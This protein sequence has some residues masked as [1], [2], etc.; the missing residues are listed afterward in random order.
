[1]PIPSSTLSYSTPQ[2]FIPDTPD[3]D[4]LAPLPTASTKTPSS[5]DALK[6]IP[7]ASS[8]HRTIAD[9]EGGGLQ[10]VGTVDDTLGRLYRTH[11][12]GGERIGEPL[13]DARTNEEITYIDWPEG[14][15]EVSRQSRLS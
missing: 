10:R 5:L 13:R 9:G 2:E 4:D 15:P 11:T 6:R 12:G 14:D 7:T 8:H 1:M 3:L